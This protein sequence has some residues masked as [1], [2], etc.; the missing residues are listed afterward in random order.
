MAAA[1]LGSRRAL[2]R[3][4]KSGDVLINGTRA[5]LGQTVGAGDRVRY[6]NQ[7]WKVVAKRSTQRNLVYNKPTG[8]VTTRSDPQGR[9]T[10]YI[11]T[12]TWL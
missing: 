12:C 9:P 6:A 2:E 10:S 1:G 7:D 11:H 8:E 5:D 3:Q 4:I